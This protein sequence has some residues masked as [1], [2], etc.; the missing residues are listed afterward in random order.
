MMIGDGD[1]D[2]WL[3]D[4]P[5]VLHKQRTELQTAG[6]SALRLSTRAVNLSIRNV[7]WRLDSLSQ[8][9]CS[10]TAPLVSY[11]DYLTF[12]L[13]LISPRRPPSSPPAT[14]IA[15]LIWLLIFIIIS[16]NVNLGTNYVQIL[17]PCQLFARSA[18]IKL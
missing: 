1:F 4:F 17:P 14:R 16:Q 15:E 18:L 11:I 6:G 10:A 2:C 3:H 12:W 8:E 9:P 7:L 5:D 13:G